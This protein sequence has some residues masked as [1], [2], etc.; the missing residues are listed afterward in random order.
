MRNS[1]YTLSMSVFVKGLI[2]VLLIFFQICESWT[3][4]N[5][6]DKRIELD[7]TF[8]NSLR[9]FG[10]KEYKYITDSLFELIPISDSLTFL[11]L[12][13][14]FDIKSLHEYIDVDSLNKE[15]DWN[16]IFKDTDWNEIMKSIRASSKKSQKNNI[17]SLFSDSKKFDF[18]SSNNALGISPETIMKCLSLSNIFEAFDM[19]CYMKLLSGGNFKLLTEPSIDDMKEISKCIDLNRFFEQVDWNCVFESIDIG[20]WLGINDFGQLLDS[21]SHESLP[22]F[23][24]NFY[25]LESDH[26]IFSSLN[27]DSWIFNYDENSPRFINSRKTAKILQSLSE[28]FAKGKWTNNSQSLFTDKKFGIYASLLLNFHGDSK[29]NRDLILR[30]GLFFQ[31]IED[32]KQGRYESVLYS[33][34]LVKDIFINSYL[35]NTIDDLKYK[36]LDYR[37]QVG[38]NFEVIQIAS[39]LH[40]IG[41]NQTK[42]GKYDQALGNLFDAQYIEEIILDHYSTD[43]AHDSIFIKSYNQ[44]ERDSLM[45]N[46]DISLDQ[47]EYVNS[48]LLNGYAPHYVREKIKNKK[49]DEALTICLLYKDLLLTQDSLERTRPSFVEGNRMMDKNITL[50]SIRRLYLTMTNITRYFGSSKRHLFEKYY[51]RLIALYELEHKQKLVYLYNQ[52]GTTY[53]RKNRRTASFEYQLKSWKLLQTVK[54]L[55]FIAHVDSGVESTENTYNNNLS[56]HVIVISNLAIA[57]RQRNDFKGAQN[58]LNEATAF[59]EKVIERENTKSLDDTNKPDFEQNMFTIYI[60]L[61][62]LHSYLNNEIEADR[63][64]QKCLQ[65]VQRTNEQKQWFM[66]HLS[67]GNHYVHFNKNS[68]ALSHYLK[69]LR[70]SKEMYN[71]DNVAHTY[72]KLGEYYSNTI[73]YEKSFI[74]LDSCNTLAEKI[75][76]NSLLIK[77]NNLKGYGYLNRNMLTNAEMAFNESLN[78][79]EQRILG[80]FHSHFSKQ[81]N[82][83]INFKTYEGAI[84]CAIKQ[85]KKHKAFQYVQQVKSRTLID[86]LQEGAL[87]YSSVPEIFKNKR[88]GIIQDL[89]VSQQKRNALL[90]TRTNYKLQDSLLKELEII[91]STIRQSSGKFSKLVNPNFPTIASIQNKLKNNQTFIEYFSGDSIY[92]FVVTKGKHSFYAFEHDPEFYTN[93]NNFIHELNTIDNLQNASRL[94]MNKLGAE[95][96]QHSTKLYNHIFDPIK[97]SGILNEINELIIAPDNKLY[98]LPFE[99]LL[100]KKNNSKSYLGDQYIIQYYQSATIYGNRTE[101]NNTGQCK[102]NLLFVTKSNFNEYPELRDLSRPNYKWEAAKYDEL[103]ILEDEEA[104]IDRFSEIDLSDYKYL[105]FSTHAVIDDISELSYLALTN[106]QLSLF[107]TFDLNLN[108]EVVVLSA[109]QTAKGE[110]QRGGGIMGFTRGLM[111]AGAKSVVISLWPIEDIASDHLFNRFWANIASGNPPKIALQEAKQY[112]RTV[113]SKYDNPFYWAGFILFGQG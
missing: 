76:L 7:E 61:A 46:Y 36:N 30:L 101:T 97:H 44:L 77:S 38:R 23:I 5:F 73:Q 88:N 94:Y 37:K 53:M 35:E 26:E 28:N 81:L 60:N 102:D 4:N 100:D 1:S 90:S 113:D 110:F 74:Y 67:L 70:Y 98:S 52:I 29:I 87:D 43:I 56:G 17:D 58:F 65:I 72:F 96:N 41:S 54:N 105:H 59:M 39:A 55:D 75:N 103:V 71:D 84:S 92:A 32:L 85:N 51:S 50:R 109:C 49:Y 95:L 86:Q 62:K 69:A 3:Q 48:N 83:G 2:L 34:Q 22:E 64:F 89:E 31:K 6:E 104:T 63:E 8:L 111:Y 45:T 19:P 78:L 80:D 18:F 25:L 20:K 66:Y 79:L 112:L 57:Y 11:D 108:C 14:T 21:A 106:S 15:L 27:L 91:N 24:K 99:L 10:D 16:H 12:L 47:L 13:K 107:N 42:V 68:I 9:T 82:I 93:L 33:D 40:S